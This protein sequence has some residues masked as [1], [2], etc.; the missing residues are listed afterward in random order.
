[1]RNVCANPEWPCCLLGVT[2]AERGSSLGAQ[3]LGSCQEMEQSSHQSS[4]RANWGFR[5]NKQQ[6]DLTPPFKNSP[7]LLSHVLEAR[8][9]F[10]CE[11]HGIKQL[12]PLAGW[13]FQ[14]CQMFCLGHVRRALLEFRLF[15]SQ[16]AYRSFSGV[17]EVFFLYLPFTRFS[18]ESNRDWEQIEKGLVSPQPLFVQ[19]ICKGKAGM[20]SKTLVLPFHW[21]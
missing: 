18:Q 13:L 1:M 6:K 12:C 19:I 7:F 20:M 10:C 21:N 16:A 15:S 3:L 2:A 11:L 9:L 14:G 4:L 17:L 5:G 8:A